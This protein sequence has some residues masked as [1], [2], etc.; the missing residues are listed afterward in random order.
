MKRIGTLLLAAALALP[1]PAQQFKFNLDYLEAKASDMVDISLNGSTL[2]FAAKFLDSKDP[3]EAQVK[4]LINGLEGIYVKTYS[5]KNEGAYSSADIDRIRTQLRAPEWSRIV[6][7]KSV[8]DGETAEVYVRNDDK[9]ISGVAIIAEA[10]KEL[11]VVNIAGAVDLESLSNLSGHFGLP[12]LET[13][14][15][16]RP[17]KLE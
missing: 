15:P 14:P 3:D 10:P 13:V 6:R 16:A 2:Q 1:L 4:K 5:F 8:E 11:T 9:K 12:K 17:K 7:F